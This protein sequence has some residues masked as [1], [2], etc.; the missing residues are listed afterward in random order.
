M[1]KAVVFTLV[2]VFALTT[3]L[4]AERKYPRPVA[5]HLV[6]NFDFAAYPA[7]RFGGTSNCIQ[8]IRFYDADS[9][10]LLA[11]VPANTMTGRQQIIGTAT[12]ASIPRRVYALTVYLDT[13]GQT[14]EGARGRV[15]E[16]RDAG[17]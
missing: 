2:V 12:V 13:S 11:E 14:K 8:A 9:R 7:C 15:S 4:G 6:T 5:L 1:S 3:W 10:Q 17:H 16:F